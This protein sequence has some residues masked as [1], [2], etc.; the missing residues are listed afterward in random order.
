[1]MSRLVS[2]I[3]IGI[4][5]WVEVDAA[6]P[7]VPL[8]QKVRYD[9]SKALLGKRLFEDTILS[10]DRSVAC[11]S[12]HSFAAGGADPRPVSVG[13]GGKK[14]NIQSPTV[15]NARYNFRQFW[16]GRAETLGEQANGPIHNPV[17][18]AMDA[19][20][21]EKRLNA[22]ASY[23]KAFKQIYGND[24]IRYAQVIDAIVAF[25]KTL[26]TPN[27]RFDRFLR[28][29]KTLN[30]LELRGYRRFKA[31]GCITCHN[32]IN[33]GGNSYQKMGLFI[34]YRHQDMTPDRYQITKRRE[35]ENVFKVPT[36]RNIALTAPYFHDASAATLK[37]AV[38]KMSY[39]NLGMRLS[40]EDVAAIVAF[41]KTLTG[42]RPELLR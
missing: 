36:L 33:I 29:E 18:M 35:H 13:V 26:V 42:E 12:C 38:Q 16:N 32:G 14:G 40:D 24:R 22:D 7:I 21:V 5:V 4:A 34:P 10:K 11:A 17:E 1:M 41:L 20:V 19:N 2:F 31:L 30:A 15:Y 3:A 8:P 25:E 27:S 6:E 28:G 9:R 37:E 23:K 39:H